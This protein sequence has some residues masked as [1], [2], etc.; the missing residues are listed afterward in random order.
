MVTDSII[1]YPCKYQ[2][3]QER[4]VDYVAQIDRIGDSSNIMSGTTKITDDPMKLKI[5]RDW[6]R[7]NIS[8]CN[9]ISW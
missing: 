9:E 1:D 4:Y 6:S 5:A 2:E 3:I 8:C 7:R